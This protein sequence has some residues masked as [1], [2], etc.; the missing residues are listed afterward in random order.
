MTVTGQYRETDSA[1]VCKWE[2]SFGKTGT[3]ITSGLLKGGGGLDYVYAGKKGIA[4]FQPL[5]DLQGYPAVIYN[6]TS[7]PG[8]CDVTVGLRDDAAVAVA[9]QQQ[10]TAYYYKDPCTLAKLIAGAVVDTIKAGQ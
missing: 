5:G 6:T 8:Q 2:D 9:I 3:T 4:L 10:S 1:W 7:A